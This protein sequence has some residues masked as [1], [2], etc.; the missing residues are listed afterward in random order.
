MRKIKFVAI[1]LFSGLT[2]F[3]QAVRDRNV[4]PVAVSL[5]QVLRM[6]I[7]NGGN[8]EFVFNSI[9]DYKKG[10]SSEAASGSANPATSLGF[11]KTDFTV[12]SSTRWELIYGAEEPTF[13]GTDNPAVTFPLNNVGF[14][15]TNNSATRTFEAAGSPRGTTATASLFS[16]ATANATQ[17]TALQ[18]YP[19]AAPLIQDNNT[20]KANAGDELD[21]SFTLNWRAGTAEKNTVVPA[22]S[23]NAVK[24]IDQN[25]SPAPDRYVVNV[26]FDLAI[27]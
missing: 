21:N 18:V 3:G 23:M 16:T 19:G 4:I 20:T 5:N 13:L 17:V 1:L 22:N 6:T 26:L 2:V 27:N 24:I 8:I 9:D 15:I 12:S 7:N 14:T 11:Y 10:L 25:P